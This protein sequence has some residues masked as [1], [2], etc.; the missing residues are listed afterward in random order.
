M[1]AIIK[2]IK[3]IPLLLLGLAFASDVSAQQ[4]LSLK[5][6]L[7]YAVQNNTRARKAEP[8]A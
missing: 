5:D 8:R 2:Q 7:N 4:T 3:I 6:A 1:N